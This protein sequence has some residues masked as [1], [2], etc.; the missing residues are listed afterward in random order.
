MSPRA[1]HPVRSA[2]SVRLDAHSV[3]DGI[4]KLLLAPEVPL[5][6]LDGDMPEQELNLIQVADDQMAQPRA[7]APQI[8]YPEVILAPCPSVD[9]RCFR[10]MAGGE[11]GYTVSDPEILG[12]ILEHR[13]GF[14][15]AMQIPEDA[16]RPSLDP[17]RHCCQG[18]EW[19]I[20][21]DSRIQPIVGKSVQHNQNM[22]FAGMPA[23]LYP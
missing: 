1:A 17:P 8:M 2:D 5:C 23:S 14:P 6:G 19:A 13:S 10:T 12:T 22:G 4:A 7:S 18:A 21:R 16:Y 11:E 9:D 20:L 15:S 3:I